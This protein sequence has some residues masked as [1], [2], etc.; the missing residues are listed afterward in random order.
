MSDQ[1]YVYIMASTF[2]RLYIGITSEI[3][4]R[5]LQHKEGR[6][7]DSFTSK[8]KIDRLV[9]FERFG[10]IEN[11]IARETQLK[12]WSRIKKIQLI[13]QNNPT[14]RNLSEEWG[15]PIPLYSERANRSPD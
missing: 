9:Y 4:R 2:K 15:Q 8:Y 13:V 11:A 7:A 5:V 3:E 1:A 10:M 6:Y 12:K 14:W